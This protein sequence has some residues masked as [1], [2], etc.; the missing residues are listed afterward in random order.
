MIILTSLLLSVGLI[1]GTTRAADCQRETLS[2]AFSK[3]WEAGKNGSNPD[4]LSDTAKIALNNKVSPLSATPFGRIKT[5]TWTPFNVQALDT[6]LCEI[7]TFKVSPQ[8]LLSIRLKVE[9]AFGRITEVEFLQA[10]SGDQFFRPSGFPNTEPAM[11][12]E[13]QVPTPPPTIPAAWTPAGGM[14]NHSSQ[15]SAATCKAKTGAPRLWSRREIL[16]AASSYCDALKGKPFDSCAFA[17]SSC[18]RNENGVVTTNNCAV[19]AGMFGFTVKGRRWVVDTDTGVTL[20][21][22]YFEYSTTGKPLTTLGSL[23]MN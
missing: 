13:K 4:N 3:F 9:P 12:H 11:F 14:F 18:P 7:A 16:Y 10:V 15:I 5:S 19:G 20:G 22:F 1:A 17:G 2:G 21:V 23:V 6:E 8:M